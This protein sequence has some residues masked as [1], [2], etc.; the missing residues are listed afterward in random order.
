MFA[1]GV[2]ATVG[3]CFC[4]CGLLFLLLH[5]TFKEGLKCNQF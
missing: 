4:K 5:F 3:T 2:S 1:C